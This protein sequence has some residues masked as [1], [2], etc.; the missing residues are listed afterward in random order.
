MSVSGHAG[1]YPSPG[2]RVSGES[3]LNMFYRNRNIAAN[4]NPLRLYL[5]LVRALQITSGYQQQ[6]LIHSRAC[7][8][9]DWPSAGS[10]QRPTPRL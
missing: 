7:V 5:R 3:N 6:C 10:Q 9:S 8:S 4:F 1:T 2:P